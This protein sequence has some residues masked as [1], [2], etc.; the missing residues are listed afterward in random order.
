[1]R[2]ETR[3]FARESARPGAAARRAGVGSGVGGA[4][5]RA[6]GPR[7]VRPTPVA[8]TVRPAEPE[9]P[10]VRSSPVGVVVPFPGAPQQV[11]VLERGPALPGRERVRAILAGVGVVVAAATVVVGL[12]VLAGAAGQARAGSVEPVAAGPVLVTVTASETVWDV[13]R[14]VEPAAGGP[15]L[16]QLVER[17]VTENSLRSL[18][19][20]PG[21]VLRV[22]AG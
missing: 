7:P 3:E 6:S 16:A 9:R 20:A 15:R 4:R 19:V 5:R 13:A 2:S 10:A 17:I 1:M 11:R 18:A 12:G 22:P 14:R 21:Q 8:V